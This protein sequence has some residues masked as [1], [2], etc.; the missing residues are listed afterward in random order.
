[1]TD[2]LIVETYVIEI[3]TYAISRQLFTKQTSKME[4]ENAVSYYC[5]TRKELAYN[6]IV[7]HPF[8]YFWL[9]L[10]SLF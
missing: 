6:D 3:N 4:E 8:S 10:P 7:M 2:M 9:Q 1:M 5:K